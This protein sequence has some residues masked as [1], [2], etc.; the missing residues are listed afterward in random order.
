MLNCDKLE[1]MG[2]DNVK[3]CYSLQEHI[4]MEQSAL[5][6]ELIFLSNFFREFYPNISVCDF[7]FFNKRLLSSLFSAIMSYIIIVI[8]FKTN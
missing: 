1:K 2:Q 5:R 3:T 4:D 8:Q 7:F 6:E